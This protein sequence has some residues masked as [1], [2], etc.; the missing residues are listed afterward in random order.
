MAEVAE[1]AH[2]RQDSEAELDEYA[3]RIV[4]SVPR[5]TER[6][7]SRMSSILA[8]DGPLSGVARW[9]SVGDD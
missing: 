2:G 7:R 3:E 1:M 9:V 5:F 6:Q 8:C 4:C